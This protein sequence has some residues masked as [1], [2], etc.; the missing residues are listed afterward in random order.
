MRVWIIVYRHKGT[1]EDYMP[2]ANQR[3]YLE[4]ELELAEGATQY[5]ENM[6]KMYEYRI[7][8]FSD[9]LPEDLEGQEF[10]EGDEEFDEEEVKEEAQPA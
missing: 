10:E 1:N 5:L 3:A 2:V 6:N 8:P 4:D 7:F 9:E